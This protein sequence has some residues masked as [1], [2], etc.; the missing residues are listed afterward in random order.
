[1]TVRKNCFLVCIILSRPIF[2]VER[3][4]AYGLRRHGVLRCRGC[5]RGRRWCAKPLAHGRRRAE[6]LN[7]NAFFSRASAAGAVVRQTSCSISGGICA[8]RVHAGVCKTLVLNIRAASTRALMD[9]ELSLL[10]ERV[11]KIDRR[12]FNVQV[13]TVDSGPKRGRGTAPRRSPSRCTGG[14]P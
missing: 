2:A 11:A 1:M 13:D 14:D 12:H 9:A 10:C 7:Q 6:S 5:Y 8:L 3:A 4:V